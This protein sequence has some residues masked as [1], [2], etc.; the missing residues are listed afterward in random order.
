MEDGGWR[1][2]H[3]HAIERSSGFGMQFCGHQ[4]ASPIRR[5]GFS[6]RVLTR[7]RTLRPSQAAAVVF[8]DENPSTPVGVQE[9]SRGLSEATPPDTRS[10]IEADPGGV[11]ESLPAR[12]EPDRNQKIQR[13]FRL[14]CRR[15]RYRPALA[16]LPGCNSI[17]D[18]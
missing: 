13:V 7:Q 5:V 1:R 18:S 3:P 9:I 4:P 2:S 11:A 10:V 17:F 12:S 16:P 14:H 15:S 8:I 6:P